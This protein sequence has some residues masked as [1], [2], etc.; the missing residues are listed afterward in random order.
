M[1]HTIPI[2]KP[3]PLYGTIG[4]SG[5]NGPCGI[6]GNIGLTGPSGT[7]GTSGS[8]GVSTGTYFTEPIIDKRNNLMVRYVENHFMSESTKNPSMIPSI[9]EYLKEKSE[10]CC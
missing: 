8:V 5:T 1:G 3:R 2:P 10:L 4:T 6:S 9:E 7:I